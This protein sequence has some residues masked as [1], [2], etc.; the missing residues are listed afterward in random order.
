MFFRIPLVHFS[1][2]KN[3]EA[4]LVSKK[5]RVITL[6]E[7]KR[8]GKNAG[9]ISKSWTPTSLQLTNMVTY[10]IPKFWMECGR[11]RNKIYLI[12]F[13]TSLWFLFLFL[14]AELQPICQ[15][16]SVTS[17]T[18]NVRLW[19][20]GEGWRHPGLSQATQL[21]HSTGPNPQTSTQSLHR[22]V[23]FFI[24]HLGVYYKALWKGKIIQLQ[25]TVDQK[26]F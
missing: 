21:K 19:W 17:A 11:I 18:A 10:V 8:K 2:K 16:N 3:N 23:S 14:C 4:F 15:D 6:R 25:G 9:A 13:S 12:Y 22:R 5:P 1:E 24:L 7:G 26:V 20:R